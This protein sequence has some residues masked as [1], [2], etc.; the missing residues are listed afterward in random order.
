VTVD[1]AGGNDTITGG[2]GNDSINGG[3][4]ADSLT[5]GTGAD[6]FI[7]HS[8]E[9][10]GDKVADFSHAAGDQLDFT[11]YGAGS[12]FTYNSGSDWIVTDGVTHAVEH[13][14]LVGVV[15][16]VPTDYHFV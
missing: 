12:T 1:G 14:T 2:V 6:H 3:A 4:G 7:F 5:G 10:N 15:T 13:I 8:G 11:G 9:A 16:L